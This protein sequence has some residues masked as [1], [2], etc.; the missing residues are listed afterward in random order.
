MDFTS[1]SNPSTLVENRT[2][3][4]RVSTPLISLPA[5][6]VTTRV[7]LGKRNLIDL[8]GCGDRGGE[9]VID[10]TVEVDCDAADKPN[11]VG[12]VV[13]GVLGLGLDFFERGSRGRWR[14]C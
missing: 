5:G 1:S 4:W 13:V 7:N 14:T 9:E 2:A 10:A 6:E 3:L 11:D 12:G 8:T